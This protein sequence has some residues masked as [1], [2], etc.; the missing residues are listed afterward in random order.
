M[1]IETVN[2]REARVKL[3]DLL[4]KVFSRTADIVIERN[5]KPIAAL[6]PIEDFEM[7]QDELDD[8]RATR[9]AAAAYEAW[10][11]EPE[12]GQPYAGVRAELVAEG[13]LDE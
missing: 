3:R 10:K 13:L 8:L 6:I 12:S 9:R 2:S 11:L 1:T 4:D 7:L 5:G